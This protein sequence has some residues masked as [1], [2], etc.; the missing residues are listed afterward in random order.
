MDAWSR[1]LPLLLFLGLGLAVGV[2]ERIWPLRVQTKPKAWS[3]NV[4][5]LALSML[6][7]TVFRQVQW[8]TIDR[9]PSLP[10]FAWLSATADAVT[11]HLP[12]P[13]VLLISIVLVDFFLYLGHRMLHTRH[14]W[15][16]H[17]VHHSPEH[18]FWLAGNRASPVHQWVQM[19]WAAC[20]DLV[21]PVRGGFPSVVLVTGIYICIQ[22]FNHA[23]LRW[24]LGPLERLFV[25][26]RYHFVHHGADPKLN[27]SNYGFLFTVWDR[28]FGTYTDPD[29]VPPD[30]ALGLNYEVTLGRLFLGI[31]PKGPLRIR[32]EVMLDE[33]YQ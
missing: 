16:V 6:F 7:T 22:H 28:M 2:C 13:V 33:S 31:P 1:L 5:A 26:P 24:R 9:L 3:L 29:R 30:F 19:T 12:W 15:H 17:A 18:L 11:T 4:F 21:L 8:R 32:H 25:V 14:L 27:N 20:I 10:R 23:N